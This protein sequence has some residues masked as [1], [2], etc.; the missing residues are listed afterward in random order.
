MTVGGRT[1]GKVDESLALSSAKLDTKRRKAKSSTTGALASSG[2]PLRLPK[3]TIRPKG[4]K[5][6]KPA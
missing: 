1:K 6:E 4:R 2:I 5:G 3:K